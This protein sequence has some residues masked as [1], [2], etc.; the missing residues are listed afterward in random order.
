[1][2][3]KIFLVVGIVI[4]VLSGYF[5]WQ[6]ETYMSTE[7]GWRLAATQVINQNSQ[8]ISSVVTFIN[9]ATKK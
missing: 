1:M 6:V 7:M 3:K 8:N 5:V 9:K 4:V 2:K